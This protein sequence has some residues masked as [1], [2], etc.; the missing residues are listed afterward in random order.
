[1]LL[2][3]QFTARTSGELNFVS[4]YVQDS[5]KTFGIKKPVCENRPEVTY[6]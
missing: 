2:D 3:R 4:A 5:N 1:M 6:T